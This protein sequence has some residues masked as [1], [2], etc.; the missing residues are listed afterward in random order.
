MAEAGE[1]RSE[2]P[3]GKKKG[4]ARKEG[5]IART[6]ELG[7]WIS[8]LVVGFVIGPLLS[9]ELTSLQRLFHESLRSI[10]DPSV[11]VALRMLR[12][13]GRQMFFAVL[14]LSVIVLAIGV[15]AS[16]AQGGFLMAPKRIKPKFSQLN[17]IKGF[18]HLFGKETLWKGAKMLIK[19]A[20]VGLVAWRAIVEIMPLVGGLVPVDVVLGLVRVRALALIRTIGLIGLG[21]AIADY[22]ITR[23]RHN[24]S[25]MMT[26]SEVKQEFKNSEGDPLVK[27]AIRSKQRAMARQRMI[28]DVADADVLLVNPTHI[29]IALKY[30][31]DK[32]APRVVAR[33]AGAI[34]QKIRL[35]AAE[36]RVPLVHDVP[37]ARALYRSCTVGSEIPRELW[38]AVAQ[39]LAFVITR[40][41]KG[42][43]GGEHRTPRP[44][45]REPLPE[46]PP[47]GRRR[48]RVTTT[49][50]HL[51]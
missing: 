19:S 35:A 11:P 31:A 3:T 4:E 18:K 10:E 17:L 43:Y 9:R 33:G 38:S 22:V 15:V 26:K 8:L 47:A 49:Q 2:K 6:P 25:L 27:N 32:G 48:P 12:D 39:V 20:I 36:N 16:V 23:R 7:S 5:R 45:S 42:Q 46:V 51:A 14:T 21:F 13:G 24:K 1:D 40:R 30:D 28:A 50:E 44:H 29:A 41:N 37:L 34:A